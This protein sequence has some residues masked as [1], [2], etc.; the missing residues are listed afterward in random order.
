[1][2]E[3]EQIFG[4]AA[5]PKDVTVVLDANNQP[6]DECKVTESDYK[7][8]N[9]LRLFYANGGGICYIVSVGLYGE[10]I[11]KDVFIAGLKEL[12]KKTNLHY[13]YFRMQ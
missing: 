3:Y 8:Y 6:T 1:M 2:L 13:F 12:E 5:E 9:S 10:A 7:L 11:T 4:G